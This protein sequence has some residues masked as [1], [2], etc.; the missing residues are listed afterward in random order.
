MGDAAVTKKKARAREALELACKF[1]QVCLTKNKE[2]MQYVFYKRNM[3]R[4]TVKEF[5]IGYAPKGKDYLVQFLKKRGFTI[6]GKP[7][8]A[9]FRKWASIMTNESLV[10]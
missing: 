3:N 1:Y 5:R 2:V 7:A 4:A 9:V 8:E 10:K 6:Q